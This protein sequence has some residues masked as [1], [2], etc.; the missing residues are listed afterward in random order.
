MAKNWWFK[1]DFRL[2]RSDSNL[3]RCSFETRG[4]WLEVLCIMYEM[5]TYKLEGSSAELARLVGCES[6]EIMRCAVELK[7]T[8]TADVTLGN[9]N[10]LPEQAVT[11]A[12]DQGGAAFLLY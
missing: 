2:W 8:K 7:Q 11:A 9:G 1:F 3:R 4:L 5:D 6:S 12:Q 10:G